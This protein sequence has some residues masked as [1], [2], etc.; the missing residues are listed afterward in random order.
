MHVKARQ[1][2]IDDLHTF[3]I[4]EEGFYTEMQRATGSDG[5]DLEPEYAW[6]REH[7][8][9]IRGAYDR[10]LSAEPAR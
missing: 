3:V 5:N 2:D 10:M 9:E 7:E 4:N 6:V 1:A 8:D